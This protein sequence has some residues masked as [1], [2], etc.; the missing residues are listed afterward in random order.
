MVRQQLTETEKTTIENAINL[1]W[2][3]YDASTGDVETQEDC[4]RRIFALLAKLPENRYSL[5][6]AGALEKH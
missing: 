5:S 3:I 2:D 4:Q 6:T 1:L